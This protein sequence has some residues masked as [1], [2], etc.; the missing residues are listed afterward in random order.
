MNMNTQLGTAKQRHPWLTIDRRNF[1]TQVKTP[2][3]ASSFHIKNVSSGVWL[4]NADHL[5]FQRY[6][7]VTMR[8]WQWLTFEITA[9]TH[10]AT[11]G[12]TRLRSTP[13]KSRSSPGNSS[14]L[15]KR[16]RIRKKECVSEDCRVGP[17]PKTCSTFHK[18]VR[19][20]TWYTHRHR[21]RAEKQMCGKASHT[22]G[23]CH[24][25][26]PCVFYKI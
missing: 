11:R 5:P 10:S 23:R 3:R 20:H 24:P 17:C 7:K 6:N 25:G 14:G 18:H 4:M 26:E 9:M 15:G 8:Q 16:Q 19:G 1:D 2:A 22:A 12:P 13:L 21:E